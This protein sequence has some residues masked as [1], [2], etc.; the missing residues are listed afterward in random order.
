MAT[1]SYKGLNQPAAASSFWSGLGS[2]LGGGSTP[3]YAGEG[4]PSSS[5][6]GFLGAST[7][8]YKAGPS[9][10]QSRAMVPTDFP[11]GPFA[12]VV[13]RSFVPPDD[14]NDPQQ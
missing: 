5:S 4:Q 2:W 9:S 3:G 13:P 6:T 14:V 11:P 7:P 8:A 1:P 12:I 10:G